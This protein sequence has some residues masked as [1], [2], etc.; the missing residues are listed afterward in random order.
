MIRNLTASVFVF[1]LMISTAFAAENNVDSYKKELIALNQNIG[2]YYFVND[3][4]SK[5]LADE[6]NLVIGSVQD[7]LINNQ[8]EVQTLIGE[9]NDM[10][11]GMS[12]M[13]LAFNDVSQNQE[14]YTLAM[15]A[16]NME[17]ELAVFLANI[18]TAAGE[19]SETLVSARRLHGRHILL[20]TGESIGVVDEVVTDEK[21]EKVVGVLIEG[22]ESRPDYERFVLPYPN[23]L[24]IKN[25]GFNND[26][27]LAEEYVAVIENFTAEGI[28]N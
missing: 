2:T 16:E 14:S 11:L 13:N 25:S 17:E 12:H 10:N 18:E 20:P 1:G 22:L 24:S 6:N 9:L 7:F 28:P 19:E 26:L 21:A 3:N 27:E 5:K 8:G 15:N 23:G 4:L